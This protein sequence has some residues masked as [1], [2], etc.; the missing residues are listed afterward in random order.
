MLLY[1]SH[2]V[3][4]NYSYLEPNESNFLGASGIGQEEKQRLSARMEVLLSTPGA[5]DTQR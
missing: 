1:I 2:R 4:V 5:Q 3:L